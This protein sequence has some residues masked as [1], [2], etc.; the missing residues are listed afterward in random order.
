[1]SGRRRRAP[2]GAGR[3]PALDEPRNP[4]AAE[5]RDQDARPARPHPART[6]AQRAYLGAARDS[7]EHLLW[8][9]NDLLDFARASRPARSNS[10]RRRCRSS[11]CTWF[12]GSP[13]CS[14]PRR[15]R[16][17][18]TS[19]GLSTRTMPDVLA[20]DEAPCGRIPVQPGWQRGEVQLRKPAACL[21]LV[22]SCVE[23]KKARATL[24]LRRQRHP[25][26][27]CRRKRTSGC[28]KNSATPT[29]STR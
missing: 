3:V 25:A 16:R 17:V 26:P 6:A 24:A 29:P 2:E 14:A 11:T 8:L 9:V 21:I 5:R 10:R 28:S 12:R 27:A 13:N 1:M 4:H 22:V 18:S 7:A 15:T 23:V 19:P 20:D